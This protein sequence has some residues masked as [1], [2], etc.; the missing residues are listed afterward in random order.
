[1]LKMFVLLAAL[2]LLFVQ[3][4]NNPLSTLI[5]YEEK[6]RATAQLDSNDYNL[7]PFRLSNESQHFILAPTVDETLSVEVVVHWIA[8]DSTL[9]FPLFDLAQKVRLTIEEETYGPT[10]Q[11]PAITKE[12]LTQT[13]FKIK[14]FAGKKYRFRMETAGK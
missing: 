14:L 1:M 7:I 10:I 4:K 6:Q 2:T 11:K 3:S 13:G 9:K 5:A 8:T 12:F